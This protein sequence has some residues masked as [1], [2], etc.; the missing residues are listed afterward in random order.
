MEELYF[1]MQSIQAEFYRLD[2]GMRSSTALQLSNG[3]STNISFR[4]SLCIS[5]PATHSSPKQSH[6]SENNSTLGENHLHT[7]YDAL[8]ANPETQQL[9]LGASHVRETSQE[10]EGASYA[11]Q[12]SRENGR[13]NVKGKKKVLFR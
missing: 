3:V 5:K 11:H 6:G 8:P 12:T 4:L 13:G 1:N 2:H 10:R 9:G 7:S